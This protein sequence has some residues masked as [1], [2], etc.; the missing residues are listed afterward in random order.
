LIDLSNFLGFLACQNEKK[1]N[2]TKHN[3]LLYEKKK[4]ILY[5]NA[6]NRNQVIQC[7]M[8]NFEHSHYVCVQCYADL[9]HYIKKNLFTELRRRIMSNEL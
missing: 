7:K 8:N 3:R 6:A 5:I 4:F 2:P 9:D 1:R